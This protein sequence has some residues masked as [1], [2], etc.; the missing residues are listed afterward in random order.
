MLKTYE[1]D[2]TSTQSNRFFENFHGSTAQIFFKDA[3]ALP[4]KRCLSAKSQ[5]VHRL[6]KFIHALPL[7]RISK[8]AIHFNLCNSYLVLPPLNLKELNKNLGLFLQDDG[9]T[10][11][12]TKGFNMSTRQKFDALIYVVKIAILEACELKNVYH[13][14]TKVYITK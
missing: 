12:M 11:R 14:Y 13:L 9:K 1:K 2:L 6:I 4:F 3:V 10:S 7:P 5:V 8:L